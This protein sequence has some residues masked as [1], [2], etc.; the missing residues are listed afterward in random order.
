MKFALTHPFT[1]SYLPEEDE[2]LI[3]LADATPVSVEHYQYLLGAGFRRSG[4]HVYRPHCPQCNACQSLRIPVAQ[5][6]PS[7]GQRKL[8]KATL[9]IEHRLSETNK[10]EYYPMY[11][12]YIAARHQDGSMYP[13]SQEQ[14]HTFTQAPWGNPLYLELWLDSQ[15]VGL[16]ITD[17]T[18][19]ALSALYTFFE[20]DLST[21]SLGTLAILRQIEVAQ[22]LGKAHLYLGYQIDQCDKMNYKSRFH[23]H[24][25]FIRGNWYREQDQG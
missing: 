22:S 12:R 4:E 7:R 21:L 2:Q 6:K 10:T 13:P 14:Y 11:A 25:K 19:Q 16:A 23:P 9:H 20:P 15:L 18:K 17:V 8:I 3:V 24:E 1:C 5:F